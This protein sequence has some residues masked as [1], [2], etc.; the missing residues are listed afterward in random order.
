MQSIVMGLAQRIYDGEK[1]TY[2]PDL[3]QAT[4]KPYLD[5]IAK[6]YG[7]T[8]A[9]VDWNTPDAK[10]LQKL[11]ENVFR[12]SASKDFHILSD[13][14]AALK[15]SDGKMRSFD[16][17][18]A[19]V[20]KMN[21]KYNQNW[22]RTEY[23]QAVASAQSAA[24]WTDYGKHADKN[25]FLQYQAVMDAN[26]RAEHAA[27]HG[28]IKRYDDEFWDKYYPP[29]GWGCRCEAIQLP[30]KTHKETPAADIK[31][32]NVPDAFKVNVGKTGK[33]FSEE[34]PYFMQRCK[35]CN[36]TPQNLAVHPQCAACVKGRKEGKEYISDII[37]ERDAKKQK[38]ETIKSTRK[39]AI[40]NVSDIP[41]NQELLV[42]DNIKTGFLFHNKNTITTLLHHSFTLKEIDTALSLVNHLDELEFIRISPLGEGKNLK[43]PEERERLKKKIKER[44][45]I[46]YHIYFYKYKGRRWVIKT[47]VRYDGTE[48]LY[49]FT[50]KP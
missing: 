17:F 43:D 2:D 34:H 37:K 26:T 10:T 13:M 28:V 21:V 39:D 44:G 38:T 33:I 40:K 18:Q 41:P 15:G 9:D 35:G 36:G 25:P 4:V 27:L 3:L 32:C 11:T 45:V 50:K 47:E 46:Q 20:D 5:G 12:F 24:R 49:S 14:T 1:I 22:L 48:S 6:G 29:N 19:E 8:L 30:G 16:D 31:Y 7:K 23:N 42:L